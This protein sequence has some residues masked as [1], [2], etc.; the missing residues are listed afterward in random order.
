MTRRLALAFGAACALLGA[1]CSSSSEG[2]AATIET[3]PTIPSSRLVALRRCMLGAAS[4][5]APENTPVLASGYDLVRAYRTCRDPAVEADDAASFRVVI[6]GFAAPAE[7][8]W[9]YYTT[10]LGAG[11][12]P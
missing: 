5:G 8:A 7:G 3:P 2:A 11:P 1:G 10:S 9:P 4:P 12:A 6:A